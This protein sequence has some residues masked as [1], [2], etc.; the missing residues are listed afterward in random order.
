M[1]VLP[2]FV[3]PRAAFAD[4]LAFTRQRSREQKIGAVLAVSATALIVLAFFYDPGLKPKPVTTITFPES[5]SADRT[6]EQIVA[7]QKKHQAMVE[8]ARKKRQQEF[9][10]LQKQLR[11]E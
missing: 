7:D 6:D 1:S 10:K 11:M 2:P 5:W 8:A 4:L 9:Q 3:G